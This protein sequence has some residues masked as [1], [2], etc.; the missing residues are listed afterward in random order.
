ML[1]LTFGKTVLSKPVNSFVYCILGS[2]IDNME[3]ALTWI[4]DNAR[5]TLPTIDSSILMLSNSTMDDVSTPIAAAAAGD[6][7]SGD[8]QQAPGVIAKLF[9]KYE[10]A[11]R[12]QRDIAAIFLGLYG[13]ILLIG[14]CVFVW[15]TWLERKLAGWR[16]QRSGQDWHNEDKTASLYPTDK[17]GIGN[18]HLS[19]KPPYE[20]QQPFYGGGNVNPSQL[21]FFDDSDDVPR[22]EGMNL[23]TGNKLTTM[24]QRLRTFSP[25]RHSF[26]E[27][28]DYQE[29]V[30][31][32]HPPCPPLQNSS[33]Q[34]KL[35]SYL[36]APLL[37]LSSLGRKP[38]QKSE[39]S[40]AGAST[41]PAADVAL[42]S[43]AELNEKSGRMFT[44]APSATNHFKPAG[45]SPLTRNPFIVGDVDDPSD[46]LATPIAAQFTRQDVWQ[47][48]H[49]ARQY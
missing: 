36:A 13:A 34:T 45:P 47:S 2:K 8:G 16:T 29:P 15:K 19:T 6:A 35:G 11:L 30:V 39:K 25:I 38:S 32:P 27:I 44:A 33:W 46:D 28:Q 24:A 43:P 22:K 37:P 3:T 40:W 10:D 14:L 5:V 23:Q 31:P 49:E 17:G 12:K 21:S 42:G 1:D 41:S 18:D 20:T 48:N 26:K 9:D 7:S 4:K